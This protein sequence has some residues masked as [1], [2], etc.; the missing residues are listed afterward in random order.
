MGNSARVIN[1]CLL[2]NVT[3]SVDKVI[4]MGSCGVLGKSHVRAL[5]QI[6][7]LR[8]V[9]ADKPCSGV[10]ELAEEYSIFGIEV[11]CKDEKSIM[12]GIAKAST[13]L[14]GIDAAVYNSAIT[15]EGLLLLEEEAFPD[16]IDYPLSLWNESINI[17]L[18]GAFLFSREVGKIFCRQN[19]GNLIFVSSVYGVIS[20]DHSIYENEG[21]NTFPGY[22]ASKSGLIG[23]MKWLATLWAAKNV[24]VNCISPG[25][26]YNGQ[27]ESFV[28]KYS[29]R[30]PIGRMAKAEE[31]SEVL[32]Y[33][34]N[35]SPAYYTGQNLIVDGGLSAW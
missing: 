5:S 14:G 20:P 8:L 17:N 23:L 2:V 4:L 3:E 6:K 1:R 27:A 35:S 18:T 10:L 11:D 12:N 26:V 22:A 21:F 34:I 9:I 16:F 13:H 33:L 15:S 31:I 24:R 29:K 7:N 28:K 32:V 30:T 19:S 25:G